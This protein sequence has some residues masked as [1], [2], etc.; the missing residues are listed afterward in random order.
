MSLSNLRSLV[1]GLDADLVFGTLGPDFIVQLDWQTQQGPARVPFHDGESLAAW[2]PPGV[3]RLGGDLFVWDKDEWGEPS[4]VRRIDDKL[5]F[6]EGGKTLQLTVAGPPI[7]MVRRD[8]FW[9]AKLPRLGA[10][11]PDYPVRLPYWPLVCGASKPLPRDGEGRVGWRVPFAGG[12]TLEHR[13]TEAD[14]ED[15]TTF[16]DYLLGVWPPKIISGWR[17][18]SVLLQGLVPDY[19][20]YIWLGRVGQWPGRPLRQREIRADPDQGWFG[21]LVEDD[22]VAGGVGPR[23]VVLSTG[24]EHER[25]GVF[26]LLKDHCALDKN[27]HV[28]VALDFGTSNTVV[29]C[30]QFDQGRQRGKA[31]HLDR[32]VGVAAGAAATELLKPLAVAA[33]ESW[34]LEQPWLLGVFAPV[35]EEEKQGIDQIPSGIFLRA[36][37][38]SEK[39]PRIEAESLPFVDYA[40]VGPGLAIEKSPTD[41]RRCWLSGLKWWSDDP[42]P[43]EKFLEALLTWTVM[44]CGCASLGV[45]ATYPFAFPEFRRKAYGKLLDDVTRRVTKMTGVGVKLENPYR[46]VPTPLGGASPPLPFVDESSPL[47]LNQY[48]QFHLADQG[49]QK[50][51]PKFLF[52]ADLGGGTLDVLLGYFFDES[53]HRTLA[54]ESVRIGA[55][56]VIDLLIRRLRWPPDYDSPELRRTLL[57]GMARGGSLVEKIQDSADHGRLFSD[58]FTK[59]Q[60]EWEGTPSIANEFR[61]DVLMYFFFLCE[62][63][64][65]FL[66]GVLTQPRLVERVGRA[67][68]ESSLPLADLPALFSGVPSEGFALSIVLTGNGW[69]FL[70]LVEGGEERWRAAVFD[71]VKELTTPQVLRRVEPNL[72]GAVRKLF[73]AERTAELTFSDQ[74][75]RGNVEVAPNGF[76]DRSDGVDHPWGTLVG[77]DSEKSLHDRQVIMPI[78]PVLPPPTFSWFRPHERSKYSATWLNRS[79]ALIGEELTNIRNRQNTESAGRGYRVLSTQ[80]VFWETVVRKALGLPPI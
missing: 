32:H 20:P 50:L 45:R 23:F 9:P 14:L 12:M 34:H 64:A 69:G 36:A 5:V 66:A 28:T 48:Q 13:W 35:F 68:G 67:P 77:R 18:Y 71:R 40:L 79:S 60:V 65:R 54:S 19:Q 37:R 47:I 17:L 7:K 27:K 42:V 8:G 46:S 41:N 80:R 29:A 62:Y 59:L 63:A 72:P 6:D 24:D 30:T 2:V 38:S 52:V 4:R 58:G 1:P 39:Q 25:C 76:V 26:E 21:M 11:L 74:T 22:D 61:K 53:T 33:K 16:S 55:R 70:D 10:K 49:D 78:E 56:D 31:I 43:T 44:V 75:V 57:E 73:T 3:T 15:I 51:D